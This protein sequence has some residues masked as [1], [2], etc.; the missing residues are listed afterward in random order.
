MVSID[1]SNNTGL[2]RDT[3]EYFTGR[4]PGST[5]MNPNKLSCFICASFS[6]VALNPW[7]VPLGIW[8]LNKYYGTKD[9]KSE[10]DAS[11]MTSHGSYL[12]QSSPPGVPGGSY[13]LNGNINS[14]LEIDNSLHKVSPLN[15]F[16]YALWLYPTAE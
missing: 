16:T 6:D 9:M 1:N 2:S 11:E 13:Q 14:Y 4:Y 12:E 3:I 10:P 8:P 7:P 5:M 15:G